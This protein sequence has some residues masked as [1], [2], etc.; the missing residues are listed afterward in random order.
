MFSPSEASADAVLQWLTESGVSSD[1][2]TVSRNIDF[3]TFEAPLSEVEQLLAAEYH[4][5]QRTDSEVRGISAAE[6]M[7][8]EHLRRHIDFISPT[9][10]MTMLRDTSHIYKRS[11]S[12]GPIPKTVREHL[13][14]TTSLAHCDKAM[15]P[16]CIKALYSIP[17]KGP[18]PFPGNEIGMYEQ[19]SPYSG[20]NAAN[21]HDLLGNLTDIPPST[22]PVTIGLQGGATGPSPSEPYGSIDDFDLAVSLPIVYPQKVIMLETRY[23]NPPGKVGNPMYDFLD[24]FDK[25]SK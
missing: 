11:S 22:Q 23:D 6:Y 4:V 20:W 14:N 3:I 18:S 5:F 21:I 8:P 1:R 19:S 17:Q 7:V 16:A 13:E 10:G 15:T 2:I 25:V 24:A 12:T 9:I